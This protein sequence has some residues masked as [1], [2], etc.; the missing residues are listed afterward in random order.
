MAVSHKGPMTIKNLERFWDTESLG[1]TEDTQTSNLTKEENDAQIL[2]DKHTFY[3]KEQKRWTT[4]LLWK[5]DP[6]NLG[7]NKAKALAILK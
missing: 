3:N 2:Q 7:N 4:S 5:E 1:I 6:P